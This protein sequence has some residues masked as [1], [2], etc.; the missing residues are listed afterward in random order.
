[1]V[2]RPIFDRSANRPE[3]AGFTLVELLV[4]IAVIGLLVALLLPAVQSAR[5]AARRNQC[6]NNLKQIALAMHQFDHAHKRL[7]SSETTWQFDQAGQK[8]QSRTGGSAFIP[9]LPF[10]E[11]QSLFE[12]YEPSMNL[13]VGPNVAFSQTS[14][15]VFHCPSMV[16]SKG[17]PPRGWGSYA[18]NTGTEIS[19]WG[20]CCDLNGPKPE[21]HNG[22]IVDPLVSSAKRT[23]LRLI[24]TLDGTSKTFLAGDL[25][26]GLIGPTTECGGGPASGGSTKW[27]DGYPVGM[28]HGTVAGVFNS[29]RMVVGCSEWYTFRSDHPGGV[30]MVMADGSVH[31]VDEMIFTDTLKSLASRKD[32]KIVEGLK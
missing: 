4:T 29:D 28:S 20:Y 7:P 22:A 31:F 15:N 27:A 8:V 25:D 10:L 11:A 12:Q 2:S 1:M 6:V 3:V 13:D 30:N 32:G 23:S 16:F 5:E 24:G 14:I 26:Y 21:F 9:V 17:N 18:V 19:H